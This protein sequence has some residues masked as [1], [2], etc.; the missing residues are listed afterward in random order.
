MPSLGFWE[1]CFLYG[2]LELRGKGWFGNTSHVVEREVLP[3]SPGKQIEVSHCPGSSAG[4]L[5]AWVVD[6][7]LGLPG[8]SGRRPY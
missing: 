2:I 6:Y 1:G 8:L 4:M 7:V 3:I 5:L